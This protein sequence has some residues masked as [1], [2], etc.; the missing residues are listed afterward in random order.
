MKNWELKRN[1]HF[2]LSSCGFHDVYT[3]N[4]SEASKLPKSKTVELAKSSY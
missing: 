3:E 4:S 2:S 1:D